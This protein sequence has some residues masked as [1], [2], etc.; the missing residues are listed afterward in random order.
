MQMSAAAANHGGASGVLSAKKSSIRSSAVRRRRSCQARRCCSAAADK[1][2][3]GSDSRAVNEAAIGASL[4]YAAA[5]V[6]S[7][8]SPERP[9]SETASLTVCP[10]VPTVVANSAAVVVPVAVARSD[11]AGKSGSTRVPCQATHPAPMAEM[12]GVDGFGRSLSP[13]VCCEERLCESVD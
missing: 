8:R 4:R 10:H 11:N 1:R 3:A 9:N 6:S 2:S 12:S 5:S 7:G 13:C